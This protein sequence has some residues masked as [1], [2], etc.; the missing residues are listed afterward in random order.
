MHDT[1][2]EIGRFFLSIYGAERQIIVDVGSLDVNGSLRAESPKTAIYLGLDFSPGKDV[3]IHLPQGSNFPFRDGFADIVLATSAFEHDPAFWETFLEMVRISKPGG[4]IYINAPSNG[5]VHRYPTDCWRFYPDSGCALAQWARKAGYPITLI[6]SFTARRRTDRWND[7]V[8]IFVK[9]ETA[10]PEGATFISDYVPCTNVW[11]IGQT[12]MLQEQELTED[13][14]IIEDLRVRTGLGSPSPEAITSA[15]SREQA[16][17]RF[18]AGPDRTAEAILQT[19]DMDILDLRREID[20]LRD[21]I[22]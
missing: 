5:I 7:F 12:R 2:Y 22:G 1:A 19:M 17:R 13:M 20:A 16:D 15:S 14:E 10:S 21:D 6:E 18:K 3:D 11:R 9:S 8:A 4:N